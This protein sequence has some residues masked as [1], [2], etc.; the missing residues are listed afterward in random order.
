VK[1]LL[2]PSTITCAAALIA[3]S[4]FAA[5]IKPVDTGTPLFRI[6]QALPRK[7]AQGNTKGPEVT[8]DDKHPLL[9]VWSVRDVRLASD[10]KG[11]LLTLIE[12]DR[13]TFAAVTHNYNEGLLLL[14]GQGNILEAF[15]ITAPV[16]NGLLEFRYPDDAAV[17][18][19][20]RRRFK[21]AEFR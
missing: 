3:S 1:P 11:V 13:K 6:F 17:A 14:E 18:Q 5:E 12:K 20:L 9:V 19:Y 16:E 21:L 4:V 10:G 8:L 7:A 2:K 15:Q